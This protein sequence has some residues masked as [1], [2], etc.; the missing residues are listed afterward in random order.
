MPYVP[1]ENAANAKTR[2]GAFTET[3]Y[4][5]G[6]VHL[7]P[8]GPGSNPWT[9]RHIVDLPTSIKPSVLLNWA[10]ND[11]GGLNPKILKLEEG[12]REKKT[13]NYADYLLGVVLACGY[14]TEELAKGYNETWIDDRD[15][16]VAFVSGDDLGTEYGDIVG[17]VSGDPENDVTAEQQFDQFLAEGRK[18]S[19][20]KRR[21][22][23]Q[24][25]NEGGGSGRSTPPSKPSA[26]PPARSGVQAS[27]GQ[28]NGGQGNAAMPPPRPKEGGPPRP[29]AP[30]RP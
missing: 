26:K 22:E 13:Q 19:A 6:R 25:K 14:T 27:A 4:Y 9:T 29:P 28:S 23:M 17:Y 15:I 24:K 12:D 8:G 30:R 16:F 18:P 21:E 2:G 10:Y 11:D 5:K 7:D 3:G 1:E 20:P